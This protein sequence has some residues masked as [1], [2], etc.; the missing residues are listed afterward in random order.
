MLYRENGQFKASYRA[1]QQIFPIRQD[2]IGVILLLL[3]AFVVVPLVAGS[4]WFNAILIPFLIFA[5]AAT[6]PIGWAR[7]SELEETATFAGGHIVR[8]E[9]RYAPAEI[10]RIDAYV[11]EHGAKLGIAG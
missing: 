6:M 7:G 4:Y 2:R 11:R 10:E 5:L 8:L 3:A 1:D 9:D